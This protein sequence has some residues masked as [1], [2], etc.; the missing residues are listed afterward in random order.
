MCSTLIFGPWQQW[1]GE[2]APLLHWY[3]HCLSWWILQS[4]YFCFLAYWHGFCLSH[5]TD[6]EIKDSLFH[7]LFSGGQVIL[8]NP[9]HRVNHVSFH[10]FTVVQL[11][12]PSSGINATSPGHW[13]WLCK[14]AASYPRRTGSSE[15]IIFRR[16][17]KVIN[18]FVRKVA[19]LIREDILGRSPDRPWGSPT[20]L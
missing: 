7:K 2:R 10:V 15:W 18:Y 16:Y 1:L 12:F 8:F 20:P 19:C 13:F 17:V 6:Y 14:D 4:F 5:S 11:R 3:L 9:S